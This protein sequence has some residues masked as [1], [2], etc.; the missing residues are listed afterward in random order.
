MLRRNPEARFGE[1]PGTKRERFNLFAQYS[2]S[3][4]FTW[5]RETIQNSIDNKATQVEITSIDIKDGP[6]KDHRIL[7]VKDNGSGM[8]L[9]T[10]QGKFLTIGGTGKGERE[11]ES[12]TIGG[13][14]EAKKVI[15]LAWKAWRVITKTKNDKQAIV[16]DSPDGWKDYTYDY[17]DL[18]FKHPFESG[19]IIEVVCYPER[20]IDIV[21]AERFISVCNLPSVDFHLV[22]L[23]DNGTRKYYSNEL[24]FDV[25][26][27]RVIDHSIYLPRNSI[28]SFNDPYGNPISFLV[29]TS[30]QVF[31]RFALGNALDTFSAKV[32]V[33]KSTGME[34]EEKECAKL[35]FKRFN[36]QDR[37]VNSVIYYRVKGLYLWSSY[38]SEKVHGN[39][40]ID[41]TIKTTSI[42]SDNRDSIRNKEL[43]DKIEKWI[44][45]LTE[46][47]RNKI[48][49]YTKKQTI[50]YK[51]EGGSLKAPSRPTALA[52][53]REISEIQYRGLTK[54][55]EAKAIDEIAEKA[56][57][58]VEQLELSN[59]AQSPV[60]ISID[61]A[62][63]LISYEAKNTLKEQSKVELIDAISRAMFVPEYVLHVDDDLA[64][65]GYKVHEKFKPE[66]LTIELKKIIAVW[67]EMVRLIFMMK[68]SN[69]EYAVGFVFS[70]EVDGL[71][72]PREYTK[73]MSDG[74]DA[75]GAVLINP[76][77]FDRFDRSK[78][79]DVSEPMQLEKMW[80]ICVHECTHMIDRLQQHDEAYASMLT[81]N[82]GI[83]A[84]VYPL[85]EAIVDV[86]K[87]SEPLAKARFAKDLDVEEYLMRDKRRGAKIKSAREKKLERFASDVSARLAEVG[88][89]IP[90]PSLYDIEISPEAWDIVKKA[91]E[92]HKEKSSFTDY[93]SKLLIAQLRKTI[94]NLEKEKKEKE[95][96][97]EETLAKAEEKPPIVIKSAL[98][99][100][101][102]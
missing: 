53:A 34:I 69:L 44:T 27:E 92:E 58:V 30:Y 5:V 36:K 63:K 35:Y 91:Q 61:I 82:I 77:C 7:R 49:G 64:E 6:L 84:R 54:N 100:K 47:P 102:N 45:E 60:K 89:R 10:L 90:D 38:T 33:L 52:A 31:A 28:T 101:Y 21:D 51:G 96:K 22:K 8:S 50:I 16:A 87:T 80:A 72:M 74:L 12:G 62:K 57:R 41:F 86:V 97:A 59:G 18:N 40:I 79:I 88:S 67:A 94:E 15:L 48:R 98:F 4:S 99:K 39:I 43:R 68:G 1:Q 9:K 85:V 23:I 70:E 81:S 95:L 46:D 66:K 76:Y 2:S 19:T 71:H 14:G 73:R 26:L 42:L 29:D 37:H 11:E 93:T 20:K 32:E 56:A 17:V 75:D 25:S 3:P 65:E 83:V 55:A 13:F 24:K 78:L